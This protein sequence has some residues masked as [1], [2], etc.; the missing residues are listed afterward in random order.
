M[1]L[2]LDFDFLSLFELE[3]NALLMHLEEIVA[4]RERHLAD[5][6]VYESGL[7]AVA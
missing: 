2:Q 6:G 7:L 3:W 4:G 5:G 1:S